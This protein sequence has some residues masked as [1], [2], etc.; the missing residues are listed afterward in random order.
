MRELL[1][2]LLQFLRLPPGQLQSL[3]Q[4]ADTRRSLVLEWAATW[5][6][7]V[8]EGVKASM[9]LQ[10]RQAPFIF[11]VDLHQQGVKLIS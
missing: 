8:Q 7:V 5:R 6:L 9:S 2:P 1:D 10:Q 11:R 3:S 4:A